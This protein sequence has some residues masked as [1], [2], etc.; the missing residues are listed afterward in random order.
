MNFK[1]LRILSLFLINQVDYFLFKKGLESF[2]GELDDRYVDE[3][4]NQFCK[5][6]MN[7]LIS[8]DE[9]L[10]DFFLKEIKDTSYKG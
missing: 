1:E 3:K 10:Y 2:L 6:Q 9:K 5:N 7:F 4:W 8:Y